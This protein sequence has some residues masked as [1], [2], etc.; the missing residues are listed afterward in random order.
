M[1]FNSFNFLIFFPIVA[2]GYYLI[3]CVGGGKKWL[4]NCWLLLASYYF[5]LNLNPVYGILLAVITALT[6]GCGICLEKASN[7]SKKRWVLAICLVLNFSSLFIFKYYNFVCDSVNSVLMAAG[8]HW[9]APYLK[10]LLPVGISFFTFQTGGYI[11]DVYRGTIKAER[12]VLD[13]A[14]FVSFFPVILAGPIQ[15]AKVFLLQLKEKHPLMYDNV[16]TG[17]KMMLWGYFMKLCVADRLKTYVDSVF[18][19][20]PQHNGTSILVASIF[21]TIQIYGDFAGYS[22]TALGCARVMGFRLPDNFRRPYF[23]T[24][25]KEF[26]KRWHIALSSWFGDYLYISLGGNRVKYWR[27]LLNLMIV[28]LVSGLWHGAAWTFILWGALH[29]LYQILEALWKKRFGQPEYKHWW[30]HALKML[31][32]FVLV[33]MAWVFFRAGSIEDAF[34]AIS[35]MFTQPGVPFLSPMA[36]IFGAMSIAILFVKDF[37]DEFRPGW[38]LM[39]SNNKVVSTVTCALLAIY[40]VLFGVLDSSQFIYFQF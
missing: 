26:W 7:Q 39:S 28:F 25:I 24:S 16:I 13:Y 17:L 6:Y 22:L 27:Y 8:I 11:I 9:D 30:S 40:V 1:L 14:L 36:M 33:N 31:F 32:I 23:S 18:D 38:K 20:L 15:R 5:Y 29:G 10:V 35:K 2:M 3:G 21:Y 19:N 34:M 12:N 4:S 37:A